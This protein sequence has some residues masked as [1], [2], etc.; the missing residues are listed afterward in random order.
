MRRLFSSLLLPGLVWGLMFLAQP[1][2]SAVIRD[3][4]IDPANLGK[5]DWIYA[6]ADATNKLGGHIG[7]VT[8]ETSLMLFYQS[9]GVRY[10]IIKAAS[11]PSLFKGCYSVPQFNRALVDIAHSYGI[12]MFGYNRSDGL[13]LPGEIAISDYVFTQGGDGFVWDAESEWES[14]TIGPNGASLAWQLCS[15]VRSNWPSKFLAHA[16]FPIISYHSTFPYKEFGYFSDAVMPQIYHFGWSNVKGSASGGIDWTDANWANWQNSLYSLPPTNING[17]TIYWTNSIKPLAPVESVYGPLASSPCEGNGVSP[18]PDKNVTEFIDYLSCD[19]N[20][21]TA[22]G[23]RGANFWRADLHG[24]VQFANLGA[25]TIGAFANRVNNIVIDNPTATTSGAWMPVRTFSNGTFY[26]NGSGTDINSFGTNYLTHSLGISGDYVQFTPTILIPGTYDVYQWHVYRSDASASTP[27]V[28][29][30]SSGST[31]VY[32]NQQTNAGNWSLLGRFAF[33]AGTDG[34]VR[35]TD[36]ITD[37]GKVAIADGIKLVFVPPTSAPGLPVR[38]RAT[39][40]QA[41][42]IDLAW[43]DTGTNTASFVIGRSTTSGG[44]YTDVAA[45]AATPAAYKDFGLSPNTTYY[46][47]VRATNWAGSSLNSGQASATTLPLI[48]VRLWGDSSWGQTIAVPAVSNVIALASGSWH[49]LA[50]RANGSVVAWGNDYSGQCAVPA[51]LTDALAIAAGGYHSLALRA[52]GTVLAWGNND[53][54]QTNVPAGLKPVIGVAAGAWHCLA[55]LADGTVMAWGDD[56]FGQCSVPPGLNHVVG[57]AAGGNHSLALLSD[58][59]V[60]GWGENTDAEGFYGGQSTPPLGLSNV[61]ALAAGEYHSLAVLANGQVVAWGDDSEGQC[62]VSAGATNVV[63]VAAGARH[64]LALLADGS[65][66]AWG[67]NWNGQCSLP[68]GLGD[69]V[70]LGAGAAHSAALMAGTEPQAKLLRAGWQDG[71]FSGVLQTLYRRSYAFDYKGSLAGPTWTA[72]S[73]NVG[74]GA[75]RP[76]SDTN[77]AA[78]QGFYRV[79]QWQ[80]P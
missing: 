20:T 54:G 68:A 53:Y 28:I 74:N 38:L 7:S 23:Y 13:N 58:G 8:N 9:Q 73:T 32:A 51:T 80:T 5:G 60:V 45:T 46:Y 26:G 29:N 55:L 50:L 71:Q 48:P 65:V 12:L 66:V 40:T 11:G 49:N 39:P 3:G 78:A 42:E 52:N 14:A 37:S 34:Y 77:A 41:T 61:V 69:V 31:L 56:S 4:G 25:G 64:S 72:L 44:P 63:A 24:S 33:A 36:S 1:R 19:P 27:F 79:R 76:M 21:I 15:A 10:L 70:G 22:G 75:L 18:M 43:T 47:V 30:H 2:V 16:P 6:M 59:Q 67:A 62:A 57:L 17:Q 35:L